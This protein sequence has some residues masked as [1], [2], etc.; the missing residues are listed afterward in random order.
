MGDLKILQHDP[1]RGQ[2]GTSLSVLLIKTIVLQTLATFM[3]LLLLKSRGC[4]FM[5][6]QVSLNKKLL[7]LLLRR[8]DTIAVRIVLYIVL[9]TFL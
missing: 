3:K 2:A 4:M 7:S 1:K 5:E 6:H 9:R 8:C